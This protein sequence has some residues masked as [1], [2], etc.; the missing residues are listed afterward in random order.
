MLNETVEFLPSVYIAPPLLVAVE[1]VN[2]FLVINV[3]NPWMV[4]VPPDPPLCSFLFVDTC[5]VNVF[6]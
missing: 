4:I 3:S 6:L 2:S 1:S 5:F